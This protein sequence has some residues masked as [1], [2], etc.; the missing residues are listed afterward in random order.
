M[1]VC[2]RIPGDAAIFQHCA[3]DIRATVAQRKDPGSYYVRA[4]IKDRASGKIGTGYQ[5]LDIS[6]LK[7][8]GLNL[9]SIFI[10]HNAEDASAIKSGNIATDS[11]LSDSIPKW[12]SLSKSP[13]LRIYTPGEGFDCMAIVYNA[14]NKKGLPPKLEYQITVFKDGKK[15]YTGKPEDIELNGTDDWGRIP[16]MKGLDFNTP[17]EEGM[18]QFQLSV[19]DK[20]DNGKSGA[21]VQS[22]DFEILKRE[23]E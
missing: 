13:A 8:S 10:L 9:S 5:F 7:K 14:K 17:M 22:I 16:I 19:T 6:D 2:E 20:R 4:A 12:L 23:I 11:N 3:F 1:H 21:A 15:Y 18:Y